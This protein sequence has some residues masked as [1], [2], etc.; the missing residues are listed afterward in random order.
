[1]LFNPPQYEWEA[2]T[3]REAMEYLDAVKQMIDAHMTSFAPEIRGRTDRERST[4]LKLK[5]ALDLA[6][7]VERIND[8]RTVEAL[9]AE[10]EVE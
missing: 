6:P 10:M 1:M 8:Q 7:L 9:A 5:L 3:V 4:P 2:T